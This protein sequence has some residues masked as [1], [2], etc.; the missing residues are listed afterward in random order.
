MRVQAARQHLG[1]A[2]VVGYFAA[3]ALQRGELVQVL[4]DVLGQRDQL[5][6]LYADRQFVD[7]K[8]R[9]F[10]DFVAERI[11]AVRAARAG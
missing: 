9:V 10:M 8:V 3:D 11:A 2:L 6:L 5:C 7:P 4:P 1:I